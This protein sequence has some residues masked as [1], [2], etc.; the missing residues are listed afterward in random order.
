MFE[1]LDTRRGIGSGGGPA[2]ASPGLPIR[3]AVLGIIALALFAVLFLRLWFLQILTGDDYRQ[4]ALGNRV[5]T[6][7]L[8]AA[9]GN[10]VDRNGT[11]LVE[12]RVATVVQLDPRRLPQQQRAAAAEWGRQMGL[13]ALRP[14]GSRGPLVPIPA[15][16][17]DE[18]RLRF[19][20]LARVL[21]I[22]A[23]TLNERVVQQLAAL[24]YAN[25]RLKVDVPAS[26]RDYLLENRRSFPGISVEQVYLRRYPEGSTAAQLVGTTGEVSAKELGTD[27]FRGVRPGTIVGQEGIERTYDQYLRGTAGVQS[28]TVDAAGRPKSQR[29][30]R[31]PQ[32][33]LSLRTTLD[34]PLQQSGEKWLART[35]AGGTGT[36]GA[37]VAIDPRNGQILAMGSA[38]TFDPS[39]LAAPI[40]QERYDALFGEKASAPRL[41][42]AIAGFYP[43]GSI[44]KPITAFAALDKQLITPSTK[45]ND[46]GF[47]TIADRD[48]TNPKKEAYGPIALPRALQVSS[49]VF[50][51]RLGARL[52]ALPGQVLQGWA[53]RLG[54]GRPTGVDLTGEGAGTVPDRAWRMRVGKAEAACRKR[55]GKPSCGISD[56]RP[57]S[58][59]DNVNLAVGQGDVQVSP[60]QMAVAYSALANGGRIVRPHVG[61][62]VENSAGGELQRIQVSAGRKVALDAGSRQAILEGL[63]LSTRDDG[64]SADVFRDWD[65]RRLPVYG[66]TGTAERQSKADQ[67]WFVGFVQD[68]DRPILIV[69]TI[70]EGGFGAEAAAPIVCRMLNQWYEQSAS[71]TPGKSQTR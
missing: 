31:A 5:R 66:K 2:Q 67:S 14:E 44:F 34:L 8:P 53:R 62:A 4:Q 61:L 36:A 56:M 43:S 27:A 50:F 20:A 19:D 24:P 47:I 59:G 41:N 30:A 10:V 57:W 35:I 9:R 18:L 51:Y 69:A 55:T 38:P 48:F 7:V 17:T 11:T 6:M 46:E 16:A 37:F 52:N 42:R 3:V 28:I 1:S 12:N 33:G 65:Q 71:C 64:T 23:A 68:P 13:R 45:V 39:V 21:G 32:S 58:V 60:L 49:D 15:P 26:K 70:E 25:V 29:V 54:L 22:P 40:S 63:K